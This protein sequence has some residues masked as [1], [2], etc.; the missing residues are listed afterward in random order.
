MQ[1]LFPPGDTT[2]KNNQTQSAWREFSFA[3]NQVT[4]AIEPNLQ[5]EDM[6]ADWNN[7]EKLL[8]KRSRNRNLQLSRYFTYN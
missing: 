2:W 8:A 1:N 4:R 5:L 6:I 7:I 3:F